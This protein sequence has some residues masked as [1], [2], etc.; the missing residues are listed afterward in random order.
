MPKCTNCPCFLVWIFFFVNC[1]LLVHFFFS[2][3]FSFSIISSRFCFVFGFFFYQ[4][5][6]LSLALYVHLQICAIS[7]HCQTFIYSV[8]LSCYCFLLFLFLTALWEFL[9][10]ICLVVLF[11]FPSWY[12]AT[13]SRGAFAD[14][15][16]FAIGFNSIC[17]KKAPTRNRKWQIPASML[18]QKL[19]MCILE[20]VK[21]SSSNC[22][23]QNL[24]VIL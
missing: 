3:S 11:S 20:G 6:S 12:T 19:F 23:T 10:R 16:V 7:S 9:F 14:Q 5:L 22:S 21:C 18:F 15:R 17:P 24:F 4:T 2:N 1:S 8:S 13:R